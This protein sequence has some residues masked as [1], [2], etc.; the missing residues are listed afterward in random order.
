MSQTSPHAPRVHLVVIHHGLWGDP[1]H[2]SYLANTLAD[3]HAGH[4]SPNTASLDPKAVDGGHPQ[5]TTLQQPHDSSNAAPQLVVL[6]AC[7]NSTSHDTSRPKGAYTHDGID[8]C[9]MRLLQEIYSEVKR[10]EEHG[11]LVTKFSIVG[12]SLGGLIARYTI[13]LLYVAG[14]FSTSSPRSSVDPSSTTTPTASS[15]NGR[16]SR[17]RTL[18]FQ[19]RPLPSSFTTFAT[20]HAGMTPRPGGG[21]FAKLVASVGSSSLGR[22]GLQLYMK[23]S[24]WSRANI[25][26]DGTAAAAAAIAHDETYAPN[27]H[28]QSEQGVGLLEAMSEPG[29]V[30][31][32]ALASFNR[33]DFYANAIADMTVPYR[34]AAVEEHDPFVVPGGLE[35]VRDRQHPTLLSGYRASSALPVQAGIFGRIVTTLKNSP[36]ALF[37]NPRRYPVAFPLNYVMVLFL[38][39]LLPGFMGLVVHKLR[40]QSK[41]SDK[42]VEEFER[43][44]ARQNGLFPDEDDNDDDD[45]TSIGT[46]PT[47]GSGSA[48][49]TAKVKA[50]SKK[51]R[52][53]W[54]ERERR[55]TERHRVAELLDGFEEDLEE[56][57]REV[58]EDNLDVNPRSPPTA[59][60]A[61]TT[62]DAPTL[63]QKGT[64]RL[65]DNLHLDAS[66]PPLPEAQHRIVAR[67]NDAKVLPQLRK[68][69]VHYEGLEN[70]HAVI[71]VRSR[72]IEAHKRGMDTVQSWVERFVV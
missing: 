11:S 31:V 46:V 24:G 9:A 62:S 56:A 23:D 66:E 50:K 1:V 69:L 7:S 37:A 19:S 43:T 34:S 4:I 71:I 30:F 28:S 22:T 42:R 21:R 53:R 17:K 47:N 48:V 20:P 15:P 65:S 41:D 13:G 27:K 60:Q 12:Y 8:V 10:L 2:L 5:P 49:E 16:R 58:G 44:W 55:L 25:D 51:P 36:L 63:A 54:E 14:F 29:S 70:T 72:D 35:L 6:N 57:M 3:H 52:R 45:D 32:R 38:P 40:S 61:S 64:L 59:H 39:I 67:L 18:D 26:A 33:V 68:F